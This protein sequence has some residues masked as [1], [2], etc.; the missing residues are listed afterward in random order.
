MVPLALP[1]VLKRLRELALGSA[2]ARSR[3]AEHEAVAAAALAVTEDPATLRQL[4][5]RRPSLLPQLIR[6]ANDDDIS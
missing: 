4:A 3:A 5:P 6:A 2:P 1:Q